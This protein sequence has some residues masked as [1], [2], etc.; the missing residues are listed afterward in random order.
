MKT[1]RNFDKY[2]IVYIVCLYPLFC[3]IVQMI[4]K[5]R[6]DPNNFMYMI[7]LVYL[8]I[9]ITTEKKIYFPNY[10]FF[11]LLFSIYT[12]LSDIFI[13]R[14]SINVQ[15][16]YGNKYLLSLVLILTLINIK[17]NSLII[18]D[19]FQIS[20]IIIIIA[21]IVILIQAILYPHF[22][23][24]PYYLERYYSGKVEL[25]ANVIT[26]RFPS[27]YSF[28]G[29]IVSAGVSFLLPL[30]IIISKYI[31]EDRN[32]YIF[33]I[34]IG[35]IFS[36]ITKS[37]WVML[38]WIIILFMIP[39][40]KRR[41]IIKY[42]FISV[43][44]LII[45]LLILNIIGIPVGDIF[46][47]RILQIDRGGVFEGSGGTRILAFQIFT[48]FFPQNPVFG[49]GHF[50]SNELYRELDGR[51]SQIH[52]GFLSLFYYYGLIGGFLYLTFFVTLL[53][54]M[55]LVAKKTKLWG[56]FW[57]ML[58]FISMNFT[59][60]HLSLFF[61]GIAIVFIF[62]RYYEQML[63]YNSQIENKI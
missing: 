46:Y 44:T 49:T 38:G 48:K 34:I 9:K 12:I 35:G 6:I 30:S 8:F 23:I 59:I 22:L 20:K 3:A 17:Y 4:M 42:F 61:A 56:P 57:G 27:I 18:K 33:Y 25:G 31:K 2:W 21:F 62:H 47:Y 58:I 60:V 52:V 45:M 43:A 53:K 26:D 16:I 14:H 5:N 13:L 1:T 36:F 15:L 63:N 55:Y 37:R 29:G 11:L 41:N 7:L 54:K 40:Y 39:F 19:V 50:I 32:V 10:C 51:S 24:S 28:S